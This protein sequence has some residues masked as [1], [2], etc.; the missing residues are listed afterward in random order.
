MTTT[1]VIA[2]VAGAMLTAAVVAIV[3]TATVTAVTAPGAVVVTSVVANMAIDGA[4]W[5]IA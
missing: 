5:A 2:T 3:A 4:M 1:A